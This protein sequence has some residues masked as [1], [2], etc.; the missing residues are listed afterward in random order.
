MLLWETDEAIGQAWAF[1]RFDGAGRRLWE[2]KVSELTAPTR[3]DA[4]E[5]WFRGWFLSQ[6]E[7]YVV[8]V[9]RADEL[10]VLDVATGAAKTPGP[11]VL[12]GALRAASADFLPDVVRLL[13]TK[14]WFAEAV[15][16]HLI[17]PT[18]HAGA[19]Q[20]LRMHL[21]GRSPTGAG[22][23]S[24][25]LLADFDLSRDY[26]LLPLLGRYV[27]VAARPTLQQALES[28]EQGI[29]K[30]AMAGAAASD[31]SASQWIL[32]LIDSQRVGYRARIR[33][34]YAAAM[35]EQPSDAVL[36]RLASIARGPDVALAEEGIGSLTEMRSPRAAEVLA[37]LLEKGSAR[38]SRIVTYFA[39]HP[40]RVAIPG[41]LR[42]L[43]GDLGQQPHWR[44]EIVHALKV[45]TG[46]DHGEDL[47]AW[48][49]WWK[50]QSRR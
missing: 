13:A 28:E 33:A 15:P 4:R 38:D 46:V 40:N 32:G 21:V 45:S 30:A 26:R 14:D 37:D 49:K 17:A 7:A 10:H 20:V 29:Y 6:D 5:P 34:M 12:G 18:T 11:F 22:T 8:L 36:A 16:Q 24:A 31:P 2:R 41:L 47:A 23:H 35:V 27:G 44:P 9:T 39:E 25:D 42:A 50:E 48:E 19:R 43:R 1:I 3:A